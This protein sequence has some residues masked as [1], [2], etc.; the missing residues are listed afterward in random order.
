MRLGIGL[1]LSDLLKHGASGYT[2]TLLDGMVSYWPLDEESGTRY[3]VI[4]SNDLTDNNT[5]GFTAGVNGAA[6]SF[7]AANSE[8]LSRASTAVVPHP[9]ESSFSISFWLRTSAT[10]D[11]LVGH[12]VTPGADAV[13]IFLSGGVPQGLLYSATGGQNLGALGPAVNDGNWH[14]I[15]AVYDSTD[16]KFTGYVDGAAGT[17]AVT[18]PAS[19]FG[20]AW[21]TN[22]QIGLFTA[23]YL[24]GSM[25]EVAI[26]SRVLTTDERAELYNAGSGF[27]YPFT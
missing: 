23:T 17:L 12:Y 15:L 5:V 20:S 27:F 13:L 3:D 10:G 2:G 8:S 6:A 11:A 21:A 18:D 4:G 7:V 24:T 25:D 14:H 16:G 26:W 1:R 9:S 22:F 19:N